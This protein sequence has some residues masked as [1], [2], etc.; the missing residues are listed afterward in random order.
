MQ[1]GYRKPLPQP[2]PFD[3]PYWNY[4]KGHELRLPR[5]GGCGCIF[6]PPQPCCPRCLSDRLEWVAASGRGRVWSWVVFHHVYFQSF[7]EDIP[8][9]V[10]LV[11]LEEGPRMISTIVDC[12]PEEIRCDM[13]VEV[14]FEDV[15]P[16]FTIPKFRPIREGPSR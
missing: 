7:A 15:T 10:A 3:E 5:C 16:E 14:V 11:E 8:Y 9:V 2:T 1:A 6:F 12:P 13:P 4:L